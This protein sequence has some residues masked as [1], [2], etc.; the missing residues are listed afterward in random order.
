MAEDPKGRLTAQRLLDQSTIETDSPTPGETIAVALTIVWLALCAV[1]FFVLDRSGSFDSLRVILIVLAVFM[2]IGMVWVAATAARSARIM[3]DESRRLHLAIDALR[4]DYLGQQKNRGSSLE[5]AINRKLDAIVAQQQKSDSAIAIFSSSRRIDALRGED[6]AENQPQNSDQP[7]LA[8]GTPA[9]AMRAPLAK[10]DFIRALNFPE[11]A[12]D[13]EGFAS[14]RKALKDRP[15]AQLVQAAQD[16]LTLLSQDGIYMD[17]LRPD[18]AR[19][20][21]WRRFATGERGRTIADLGGIHD[22]SSL[23]LTAGRMKQD[24][25]F[26]DACLHFLRRFDQVISRFIENSTDEEITVFTETRTARAFML[27]GRVLGT[28]D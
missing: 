8:L 18:R 28:F 19:P 3:R 12:D 27:V 11:T 17:D 10:S 15:T 20:E 25:I 7:S 23:A 26:R 13:A 14:L 9:E 22:R 1:F 21:I 4:K 16:V 6:D 24:L 2:P 5:E